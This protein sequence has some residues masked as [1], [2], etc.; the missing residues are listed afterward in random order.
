MPRPNCFIPS[1]HASWMLAAAVASA[2]PLAVPAAAHADEMQYCSDLEALYPQ[3]GRAGLAGENAFRPLPTLA[4][5]R[6][7]AGAPGTLS[8]SIAADHVSSAPA[9]KPGYVYVGN[10]PVTD[11]PVF[12]IRRG[13][14]TSLNIIN[15]ETGATHPVP[16]A[17]LAS[18]EWAFSG[19]QWNLVQGDTLDVLF[20]SRLD[21]SGTGVIQQNTNGSV[22]C[23]ASNLHTHGLLVSPYHPKRAGLGPYGD[24]VLDVTQ[25]PKADDYGSSRDT[26]GTILGDITKRGHGITSLPLHYVTDI[27]GTPG[28]NSMAS[29]EHPSGLFWY[30][31]HPHGYSQPEVAGGTTGAITVGSLTD[32]ACPTGDG[33]PG[34][35]A[36]T[37]TNVRVMALKDTQIQ[38]SGNGLWTTIHSSDSGF[39]AVSGGIRHGECESAESS[40]PGKLVVTING[41]QFPTLHAA[42]GRME[43]W[44]I[45]NASSTMS[46]GLTIGP[47]GQKGGLLPFQV[48]ATD[49]VSIRAKQGKDMRTEML[50]MPASR[51]EIA[52]PAPAQ[53]GAYILHDTEVQTG[54]SGSGDIWPDVDLARVVWEKPEA[55]DTAQAAT[56]ATRD[57]AVAPVATPVS[58]V[59]PDSTG[60]R[61]ACQFK[62]GD[63]RVIYFVHRFEKVYVGGAPS[64]T[65]LAKLDNA[66]DDE[67]QITPPSGLFPTVH[68]IFGLIAGVRHVNGKMDF[69]GDDG[70]VLHR[71]HDV[72]KAG[73]GGSDTDFP[74]FGHNEYGTICTVK[75]NV[76]PWELQ[77]W[78]GEDHNFHIHQSRFTLNPAGRFQFP[79]PTLEPTEDAHLRMTDVVVKDFLDPTSATS[80]HDTVPVPRGQSLCRTNPDLP[81]CDHKT[82]ECSG[83]PGAVRCARPGI[84][85]VLMDFSRN[86]QVGTFVYHCH[87]LEHEDG[88]MMAMISV[89]CPPGDTSCAAVQAKAN[90]CTSPLLK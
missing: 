63:T 29:G 57:V 44:R 61:P 54:Q 51:V 75:G 19:T 74:A 68:E 17:C 80:Y 73:L 2:A 64:A 11:I 79:D 66:E 82:K 60:L 53:G 62:P 65:T 10:Y 24:Y 16:D 71:V 89:L 58:V 83:A 77:N 32:Y 40:T 26:C 81:G 35:C 85:S 4:P 47:E 90:I 15:T 9:G 59:Q 27:P 3:P 52:I 87:I 8:L 67:P 70:A 45:I 30:H 33:A 56:A 49:G 6:A 39:C 13:T 25:P 37:D 5:M 20:T 72:W 88:G 18:P 1:S 22:P 31:P 46:Y 21:Y 38:S 50:I 43:I 55:G 78:T 69:F 36:L 48:L 41:V 28:V 14:G 42:A 7:N 86:E 76:E 84:L 23:Q 12:R 34:N